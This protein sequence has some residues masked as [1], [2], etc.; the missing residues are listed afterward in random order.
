MIFKLK[1]LVPFLI[2]KVFSQ[3]YFPADPYHLLEFE[4]KQFESKIP[5]TSNIFKPY[6][7][8]ENDSLEFS[9]TYR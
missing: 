3:L 4:K 8:Y 7:L 9:L 2:T 1:H 5:I 6:P